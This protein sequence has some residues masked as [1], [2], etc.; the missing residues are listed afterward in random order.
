MR[1][2]LLSVFVALA[3]TLSAAAVKTPEISA[4]TAVLLDADDGE[5]LFSRGAD[6]KM[7]PASMTKIMTALLV[8]E[9]RALD[10]K[11]TV[12]QSCVNIEGSSAYLQTGEVF[13][14]EELLYALL[15][16]SANDAACALADYCGGV[17]EF[18][19]KMNE[20]AGELGLPG[21]HFCNPSGLSEKEHYSTAYDM[22]ALLCHCMKNP[23]FRKIT[24]TLDYSIDANENRRGR[25]FTNHNKLLY[26]ADGVCGG[27]T[28]YTKSSGRCLCSYYEK[29]GVRLCAVTMNAPRD[30]DDHKALYKYGASL[31]EKITLD[32][33]GVYRLHVVGGVSD[34]AESTVENNAEI[35][36]R[37][38][39]KEIRKAVYMRRFEYAP[40]YAGEQIGSIVY[41]Q[42]ERVIY[43]APLYADNKIE[44]KRNT[45]K[46]IR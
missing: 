45:F 46:W 14:V 34:T 24:G 16:Q 33:A 1:K 21:T 20:K 27:K 10:E 44:A 26:T 18:V 30:W 38:S 2:A 13:T 43:T 5:V 17:S 19:V 32:T 42:G 8:I 3:L 12:K 35:T 31:Y 7:Q 37:K 25:Y 39:E 36:V 23:T 4:E 40:V 28:G 9:N 41:F 22:A 29:D 15:L 6:R 11:I